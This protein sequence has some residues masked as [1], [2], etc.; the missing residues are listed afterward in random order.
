MDSL[1]IS[2][3][4]P[5]LFQMFCIAQNLMKLLNDKQKVWANKTNLPS[6][7]LQKL[8]EMLLQSYIMLVDPPR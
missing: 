7:L 6:M 1:Y 5:P 2:E 3:V 8:Y 4:S